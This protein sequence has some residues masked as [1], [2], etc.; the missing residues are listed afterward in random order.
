MSLR[1]SILVALVSAVAAQAATI[2]LW[3]GQKVE[4]AE[5]VKI[6]NGIVYFTYASGAKTSKIEL[7]KVKRITGVGT[8]AEA[9]AADDV[10]TGVQLMRFEDHQMERYKGRMIEISVV[11]DRVRLREPLLRVFS[12]QQDADGQR[13]TRMFA[14]E[15]IADP[16]LVY[17][18]EEVKAAAYKRKAFFLRNEDVVIA[19]RV[20]VW[21]DG[22][23]E[24][25]HVEAE[26]D[27][28]PEAW[29]R[30]Q[31]AR[32]TG[33]LEAFD[34]GAVPGEEEL[35]NAKCLT[36]QCQV[37]QGLEN[38]NPVFAVGYTMASPEDRIPLPQVTLYILTED[39]DGERRMTTRRCEDDHGKEVPINRNINR[40]LDPV[41]VKSAS[42][43]AG[44]L[45][46]SVR[47]KAPRRVA[48]WRV[49]VHYGKIVVGLKESPNVD[50]RK[51]LGPEW[52]KN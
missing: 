37:S 43:A 31:K 11:S 8:E 26:R 28:V 47:A 44:G 48:A 51:S 15:R 10:Q 32:R 29:W 9:E 38:K 20:E 40:K 16:S 35:P 50:F 18:L 52:W 14:N 33:R 6:D 17:Q 12:L 49:E 30:T 3:K 1:F 2:E 13:E 19:W 7:L 21:M 34:P 42:L 5:I 39:D 25:E 45:R 22:K 46:E 24:L 27:D 23:L 41:A 4:D 36:V